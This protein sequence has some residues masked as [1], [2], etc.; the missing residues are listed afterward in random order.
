MGYQERVIEEK[1][2]LDTRIDKLSA[3]IKASPVFGMMQSEDQN[4]MKEQLRV[5]NLLSS[6]L[7]RRI[8]RF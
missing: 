8:E 4:A 1:E 5:M 6:I 2:Q 3:F 7:G